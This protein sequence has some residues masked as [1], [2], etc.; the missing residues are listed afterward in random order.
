MSAQPRTSFSDHD[1]GKSISAGQP[2]P[3]REPQTDDEGE[4]EDGDTMPDGYL[5]S[6]EE[7]EKSRLGEARSRKMALSESSLLIDFNSCIVDVLRVRYRRLSELVQPEPKDIS[8]FWDLVVNLEGKVDEFTSSLSPHRLPPPSGGPRDHEC[9]L[10]FSNLPYAYFTEKVL[11][12]LTSLRKQC[13]SPLG[14]PALVACM[15]NLDEYRR[16]A[17]C[18]PTTSKREI[19]AYMRVV[20][21]SKRD[22][23]LAGG[24][25]LFVWV[26]RSINMWSSSSPVLFRFLQSSPGPH[27]VMLLK[28]YTCTV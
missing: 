21:P 19:A 13:R 11:P 14:C 1:E 4:D 9:K 7:R 22:S 26:K 17:C 18:R 8:D 16:L 12:L 27:R 25:Y 5:G 23:R 28:V 24:R 20:D 6:A 2:S 3:P 15:S 10:Y